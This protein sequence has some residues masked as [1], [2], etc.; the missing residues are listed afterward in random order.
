M[1]NINLLFVIFAVSFLTACGST[2]GGNTGHEQDSAVADTT[3]TDT[4]DTTPVTDTAPADADTRPS[5]LSVFCDYGTVT[6]TTTGRYAG[7]TLTLESH[8]AVIDSIRFEIAAPNASSALRDE[9]GYYID[10]FEL[11]DAVIDNPHPRLSASGRTMPGASYTVADV[12]F[13]GPLPLGLVSVLATSFAITHLHEGSFQG[14]YEI[15]HPVITAHDARTGLPLSTYIDR[16][17]DS[18][19]P[20][21]IPRTSCAEPY[22]GPTGDTI[23]TPGCLYR[24]ADVI[25]CRPDTY[26][27]VCGPDGHFVP[28]MM[29]A[30]GCSCDEG[31]GDSVHPLDADRWAETINV[32]W[33]TTDP[34]PFAA[35]TFTAGIAPNATGNDYVANTPERLSFVNGGWFA[36]LNGSHIAVASAYD[37][38]WTN[39]LFGPTGY[40]RAFF[41]R[42]GQQI[43]VSVLRGWADPMLGNQ[44]RPVCAFDYSGHP[45]LGTVIVHRILYTDH[46]RYASENVIER[47]E[48]PWPLYPTDCYFNV[49]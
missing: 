5:Y 22:E 40:S 24:F 14:W 15:G 6:T 25:G 39:G 26:A 30:P 11:V 7:P 33:S 2:V 45:E 28:E 35:M 48:T 18:F 41:R 32:L 29:L 1:R 46:L 20:V 31:C 43:G 3:P 17:C 13:P 23:C 36:S 8:A 21:I 49:P 12:D 44:A 16:N 42:H 34:S 47:H 38:P 27:Y 9:A 10:S 37:G 19:T 4:A